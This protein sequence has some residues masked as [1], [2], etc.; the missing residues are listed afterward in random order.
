MDWIQMHLCKKQDQI[1]KFLFL[2]L[3]RIYN[4]NQQYKYV[5]RHSFHILMI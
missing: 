4:L 1:A 5:N 2:S 3:L